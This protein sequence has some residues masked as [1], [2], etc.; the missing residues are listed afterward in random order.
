MLTSVTSLHNIYDNFQKNLLSGLRGDAILRMLKC[1]VNPKIFA[2]CVKRHN[3]ELKIKNSRLGLVL[4]L[5]VDGRVILPFLEGFIFTKLRI[6]AKFRE[7]NMRSFAKIKPSRKFPN[8]QY[9]NQHFFK[10]AAE[11]Q[12]LTTYRNQFAVVHK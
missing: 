10:L 7:N 8:L 1:T 11:R 2:K 3:Y 9:A 5:S 6:Y 4:P 12:Y